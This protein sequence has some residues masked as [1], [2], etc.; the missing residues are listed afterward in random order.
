MLY[1]AQVAK[2]SKSGGFNTAPG[3]PASSFTYD[4]EKITSY[5]A[6]IKN[7][8][9]ERKME[10]SLALFRND[11]DGLQLSNSY[12]ATNPVTG[13]TT[14]NTLVNNVGKARTQGGW[15]SVLPSRQ[16]TG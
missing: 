10:W 9:F 14:N 8:L 13:L 7:Q 3:L 11:I 6:G 1:Y 2:G 16:P 12:V 5:E 15:R 4:G